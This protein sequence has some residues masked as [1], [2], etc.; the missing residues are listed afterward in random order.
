MVKWDQELQ[1]KQKRHRK[2]EEEIEGWRDGEGG[3]EGWRAEEMEGWRAEEM[4]GR[5]DGGMEGWRAALHTSQKKMF[6]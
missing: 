4:E 1:G 2:E 5:G 6:S 3:M